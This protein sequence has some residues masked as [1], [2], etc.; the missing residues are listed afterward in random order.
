MKLNTIVCPV[1]YSSGSEHAI[2][3]ASRIAIP[4]HSRVII[5]TV[6][7]PSKEEGESNSM[8]EVFAKNARSKVLDQIF[9]DKGLVVEHLNLR[10]DP[11]EVI[12]NI[13]ATKHA[14]AIVMGTHGR[15]GWTKVFMGSVAQEV[16]KKAH[17]PVITIRP[18]LES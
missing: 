7:D 1:D 18:K 11:T 8:A 16:M 14:D 4:S 3:I 6:T 5:L 9:T 17:C 15:T 2:E 13:A 10:G 12:V